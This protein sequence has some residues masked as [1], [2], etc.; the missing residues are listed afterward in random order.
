MMKKH[1]VIL[2]MLF[3][4][5]MTI[6]SVPTKMTDGVALAD[7]E[8]FGLVVESDQ[9]PDRIPLI[10]VHGDNSFK[11]DED[12]WDIF[13]NWVSEHD[14]FSSRYEIWRF[15]HNTEKL[16]GYDGH[17]GNA[18]ELGD[19]II[20]QFGQER[21]VLLLAHSR[22]GLVSRSYMTRYGEGNEGNRVLGLVTLA[23]PHHGSPAAVPDWGLLAISGKDHEDDLASYIYGYT[24]SYE[25]NVSD[26]GTMGLGWDNFDGPENG[27]P[28]RQ[29]FLSSDL[30]DEHHLS[31]MDANMENPML[32]TNQSD[33]MLYLPDRSFGTL[34]EM[35]RDARYFGRII[36]YGGYDTDL[37]IG[38]AAALNW[39]NLSFTDHAGLEVTTQFIAEIPSRGSTGEDVFH[40]MANDGMVPL[41]SAFFLK[42][43]SA[44]EPMFTVE[45][46][47]N[48][49]SIESNKIHLK[50]FTD[51]MNF[52]KA[53]ICPDF[54]HLNM[55]E[56]KFDRYDFWEHVAASLDELAYMPEEEKQR[57]SPVLE[58]FEDSMPQGSD[59]IEAGSSGCFINTC[60]GSGLF[61]L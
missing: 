60:P 27:I 14:A 1:T 3:F 53:V 26:I 33:A 43:D 49:L 8:F 51:R 20:A 44:N 36:A 2:S 61:G 34:D 57:F 5:L 54:D 52:R 40:Y 45:E 15:H 28:Y 31:V 25:V 55:V 13:L 56:G 22:G 38:G 29:F 58:T 37:G 12:R 41:Q 6:F 11:E 17:S 47:K 50:D 30:G 24:D 59:I 39:L 18:K 48:W 16:I 21:P 23:T 10:L 42:K 46:D 7:E 32:E 19:A 4:T 35:N 9:S